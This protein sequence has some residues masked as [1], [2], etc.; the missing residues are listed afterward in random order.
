MSELFDEDPRDSA[1]KSP[2]RR[3]RALV[4]TGIV[5]VVGFFALTT[6]SSIYTDRLWY[7]TVGYG[8]VFTK[9]LV[10]RI[11]LFIAFGVLMGAAVAVNVFLA[12][13]SRPLFRP[14]SPEQTNLDRYRDAVTPI[15][16]WLVVAISVVVGIFAG[17]S[18]TG[19]WRSFL[20]WRNSQPFGQTDPYFDKDIGFYVF[21][22]P[23][24]HFL[25]DF[26]MATAVIAIIAAA[27][28]HYLYG[29]IRL[30][31]TH[32][33]LSPGAQVQLSVLLGL[34]VLAK[35]ADYYLDR[36]DLVNQSNRLFTGMNNT[37]EN[38]ML[39]AKN[40]LLGVAVIC[41]VLFFLNVWRKTWQLPSLGL[42]LLVLSSIL[43]GLIWPAIVQQF[44]VKPSEA[45]KEAPYIQANIEAT[46]AAYNLSDVETAS[47]NAQP[48][49]S[50]G[51]VDLQAQT[52]AVPVI[53]PKLVRE[54][55]EQLQQGRAYYS[56]ANVLDVDRYPLEGVD[57][58]LVLGARELDESQVADRN[59]SNLHTVYTHGDGI[60]A[61]YANQVP[62][63]DVGNGIV[64]A[65]GIDTGQDALGDYERRIYFG[66]KSPGYSV[67]GKSG[68]DSA[69]VELSL[70]SDAAVAE[71]EESETTTT[72]YD[73]DGGVPI[74][75]TL[76]Q[77]L[78]AVKFGEPNFLLSG[79]VNDSSRVL[80]DREPVQR[81][82][83]VA[84]WLTIDSDTYPAVVDGRIQWIVDG[85]TT[86][87][88]YPGA[89]RESF[90]S[91]IDDALQE[92]TGLRTLPTDEINYMRSA[93]KATVDAYDGTVTLYAWDEEDPILEAWR[94]AFPD[95][96]LPKSEIP[97]E[98]LPHIRY[99]EDLFK[100]QRYQLAKYHVTEA[101]DFYQGNNRWEV[102]E[103]P[104]E[105]NFQPPYRIFNDHDSD[106]ATPSE[107]SLTSVFV[108]RDKGNLAAFVSV[109]SDATSEEFGRMQVLEVTDA[110]A[111]GPGQI[112]N[113][114][115]QDATV[116]SELARLNV[117]DE[118]P[119]IFGNLLTLPVEDGLI[120]IQPV[121]AVRTGTAGF[122][123]L[124]YVLVSYDDQVG[125]GANLTEALADALIGNPDTEPEPDPDPI[126]DPDPGPGPDPGDPN[127]LDERIQL[128]LDRAQAAFDAAEVAK[129]EGNIPLYLE[130]LERG[131][132]LFD[133][134]I[135]LYNQGQAAEEAGATGAATTR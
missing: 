52:G 69:N 89:Q 71:G 120:S 30:Q 8:D 126:P 25:V 12:Y 2:P 70:P 101:G 107:W 80:Y 49:G 79:R 84:P 17:T 91:M 127:T 55:F 98:L 9:L 100:V 26:A 62:P 48:T 21:E 93:V 1:V 75:G 11:G 117:D 24:L 16:T 36:F 90:D 18:G 23:W 43:L 54:T 32:D 31:V 115:R 5:L 28:V 67:V 72:T 81:V 53:D 109:N 19:Q 121:Y 74:G 60:I 6:F 88:R 10:T 96:V 76:R 111:S 59:W 34:F 37:A 85:Y 105:P 78:Y 86:T 15:R 110:N 95:T 106:P 116:G 58:P 51:E 129:A 46:R 124:Q 56:V 130:E 4:I 135:E 44:Q 39:P 87:D 119:P 61:A 38:A 29:G 45:D 123:I 68:A 42:G 73:G 113:E 65:E 114:M 3:S 104:N 50:L 82:E 108:P 125:I 13:R 22:L 57:T 41:A 20:L 63:G 83:K 118:T 99:P 7:Q 66:E 27:I 102:P 128:A 40:I 103:D 132:A 122:P 33:R 35:A 77:L 94:S 134:A 131:R 97:E 112:A 92:N 64:W 47:Y 133:R 14:N